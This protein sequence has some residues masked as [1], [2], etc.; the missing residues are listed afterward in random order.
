MW[1]GPPESPK[2]P[3][4]PSTA[5]RTDTGNDG[6]GREQG[7]R[8]KRR[9]LTGF[10]PAPPD[11]GNCRPHLPRRAACLLRPSPSPPAVPTTVSSSLDVSLDIPAEWNEQHCGIRQNFTK[12]TPTASRR[13]LRRRHLFPITPSTH[14]GSRHVLEAPLKHWGTSKR[15]VCIPSTN[16]LAFF[17]AHHQS[18]PNALAGF[19]NLQDCTSLPDPAG[20]GRGGLDFRYRAT[21]ISLALGHHPMRLGARSAGSRLGDA[22]FCRRGV[23]IS[24]KRVPRRTE[25]FTLSDAALSCEI[26]SNDVVHA[27]ASRVRPLTAG[28]E[29]D[30]LTTVL[31]EHKVTQ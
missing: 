29:Q 9:A 22:L 2:T 23:Y 15:D 11:V 28:V 4:K 30:D 8:P 31:F 10:R 16:I 25:M 12:D 1:R 7:A 5:R 3:S 13:D 19:N 26:R 17:N 21:L 27:G 20:K 14:D 24:R 18:T 6:D